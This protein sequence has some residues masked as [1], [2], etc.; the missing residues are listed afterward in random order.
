MIN[1]T[2]KSWSSLEDDE[3]SYND[4]LYFKIIKKTKQQ[5]NLLLYFVTNNNNN[6]NNNNNTGYK[7]CYNQLQ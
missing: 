1:R 7:Y 6:N 2:L 3:F 5:I 4:S